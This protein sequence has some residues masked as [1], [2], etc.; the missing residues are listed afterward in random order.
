MSKEIT[1]LHPYFKNER[2]HAKIVDKLSIEP[3]W[4]DRIGE[5]DGYTIYKTYGNLYRSGYNSF[6][7]EAIKED[8]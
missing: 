1:F 5:I 6:D 3:T 2:C 4:K 7:F 8:K